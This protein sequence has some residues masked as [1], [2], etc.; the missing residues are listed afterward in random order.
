MCAADLLRIQTLA[1]HA[2]A[3]RDAR[4]NWLR[5]PLE[6]RNGAAPVEAAQT[7]TGARRVEEI[8]GKI[9]AQPLDPG[10]ISKR[11]SDLK[12]GHIRFDANRNGSILGYLW[13]C[14]VFP[15]APFGSKQLGMK[16]AQ[17]RKFAHLTERGWPVIRQTELSSHASALEV[18]AFDVGCTACDDRGLLEQSAG[19]LVGEIHLSTLAANRECNIG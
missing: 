13:R 6:E 17:A 1:E 15:F 16:G 8:L 12:A 4:D 11:S 14:I 2:F 5:K 10:G 7:E 19:G 3:D 9:L 18:H